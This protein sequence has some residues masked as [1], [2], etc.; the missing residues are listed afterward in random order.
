MPEADVFGHVNVPI[1][2]SLD[3][4]PAVGTELWLRVVGTTPRG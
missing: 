4:Y 1:T 3:D 2:H